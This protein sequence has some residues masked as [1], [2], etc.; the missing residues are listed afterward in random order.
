MINKARQLSEDHDIIIAAGGDGTIADVIQGILESQKNKKILMGVIPLGSGNA[1]RKSLRIPKNVRKAFK[2][3]LT[4]KTKTI[5]LFEIEGKAA[6]FAS[7]GATADVSREAKGKNLRGLWQHVFT[8]KEMIHIPQRE[9]TIE[10]YDG[11]DD[12]GRS[13][14]YKK[15]KLDVYDCVIGKTNH[16]GYSWKIAPNAKIDDGLLDITLFEV[17]GLKYLLSFPAI[18]LGTFQKTQKHF[19]AKNAVIRGKE[20]PIQYHGEYLGKRDEV[21]I[22]ILPGALTIIQPATL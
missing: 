12:S 14:D 8:A 21:K 6:S 22:K 17:S 9:M 11:M 1:F 4:G 3:L 10:L 16:F 18:Y 19:K 7:I 15:L 2:L 20:L 13:F 5:D